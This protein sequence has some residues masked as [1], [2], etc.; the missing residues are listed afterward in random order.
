MIIETSSNINAISFLIFD[1]LEFDPKNPSTPIISIT[2]DALDE[3]LIKGEFNEIEI[4]KIIRDAAI[5]EK[6]VEGNTLLQL[7]K[8]FKDFGVK[9]SESTELPDSQRRLRNEINAQIQRIDQEIA[10]YDEKIKDAYQII[11]AKE[12]MLQS[13]DKY[14]EL[15]KLKQ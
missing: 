6:A 5:S 11:K 13:L 10:K 1:L 9:I 8:T 15:N 12:M 2:M 4:A 14:L 7:V 3:I